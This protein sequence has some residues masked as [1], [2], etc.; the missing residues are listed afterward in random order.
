M[1]LDEFI[2]AGLAVPFVVGGRDW[3]GWDCWGLVYRAY[4]D[5]FG[6][7]IDPLSGEYD[8]D[9]TFAELDKIVGVQ[10][11]TKWN[12]VPKPTFGDVRL[13]RVS[14]FQSHVALVCERGQM[15]HC[16]KATGTVVEPLDAITWARRHVGYFNHPARA[17]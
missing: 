14:R 16:T 5:V 3:S 12:E 13:F 6:I 11:S 7:E 8:K 15:F 4:L 17:A 9:V 2:R 1:S 10:R